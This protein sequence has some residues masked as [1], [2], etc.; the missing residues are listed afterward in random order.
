[1]NDRAIGYSVILFLI[2]FLVVPALYLCSKALAPLHQRTVVF[3][4]IYTGS[5]LRIQDPVRQKGFEAGLVQS[6]AWDKGKTV[7]KIETAQPLAIHRGYRIVAEAKGFMGDRYLEIEPGDES[8]PL[9]NDKEPLLGSFPLGP[10]EAI[11]LMDRLETMVDSIVKV[12][13]ALKNGSPGKT[14]LI[15]GFHSVVG[16]LDTVSASLALVFKD[17][18]RLVGKNADSMAEALRKTAQFSKE[19][20][21]MVPET[22][23]L[24]SSTITKTEKILVAAD[25]LAATSERLISKINGPETAELNETFLK[26]KSQIET[27]RNLLNG[28]RRDGVELPVKIR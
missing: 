17:M 10:T 20:N 23:T 15:S 16:K 4:S 6:I 26:L 25:S 22:V 1:M 12:T 21:T 11:A 8:A 27:V 2:V 28:I 18:E 19:M 5:F 24:L 9:V 3:D 14:S 13:F 7:V